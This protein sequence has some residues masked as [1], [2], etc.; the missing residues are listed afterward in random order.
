[1]YFLLSNYLSI[2]I[3]WA[4][5]EKRIEAHKNF[6][7]HKKNP[8]PLASF[9]VGNYFFATHYK[10]AGKLLHKGL[11]I[12]P[13]MIDVNS[14]ME[15]YE[16]QYDE[17]CALGQNGFWTAEP[18]TG[19]PWMEAF[20]G[21]Q[22]I[23]EEESFMARPYIKEVRDLEKLRFSMENPWVSKYFEFIK[24]L[25]DLSRG[26]F[27]VGA[28]IMRGQGD[29][30]GALMGQTEFIYA[31]YEEA[32]TVKKTLRK[33]VDSFLDIYSEMH[34]INQPFHGGS[35]MGFYHIWSPGKGLWFQDDIS[36]L[37]SPDLYREFLLENER[38]FC[39]KYQFTMMHL[40]PS[41][42]H[43]LD[44]ILCNENLKAL[45]INKDVGGPSVTRMLPQFKKILEAKRCLVIWG[46]ITEEDIRVVF[47]NLPSEGIFFNIILDNFESAEKICSLLNSIR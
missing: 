19:I 27:P 37:L 36:A 30:L 3:M 13:E 24:K 22:I 12:V 11:T 44:D 31:L 15:D 34:R 47:D 39:G 28:P 20:W 1:M 29:T 35:S 7:E 32:D 21:C 41:S 33:I 40:H 45:E 8:K 9:R 38:Y 14:F 43:L 6:W 46:A 25:N 10:A 17:A 18:Y 16:R 42:F 5:D 23:A 26:R 4:M 2:V